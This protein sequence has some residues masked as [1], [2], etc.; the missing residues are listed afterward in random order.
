MTEIGEKGINLSGGQKTRISLARAVYQNCDMCFHSVHLTCSYLL[1]DPLSAVD[2]HVGRHIF[3]HCIKGLLANKCVVLVT[4]ALEFL[5]ACD[6]VI[7]LEKGAIADQGTFQ[8]V[9]QATSGVLAGLLQ[10]QKEAQAQQA[11]EESPISPVEVSPLDVSPLEASPVESEKKDESDG[12]KKDESDGE[13]KELARENSEEATVAVELSPESDAKKGELTVEETV[14]LSPESDAKKG[15]LTVEETRVKGKVKRSVYW[16]Y[17]LAA[18]GTCIIVVILLLFIL[19]Q[20]VRAINNWWL[21]YWSNDSAGKDAKWYLV[22]YIILGV[23]TVVVAIIAHLVL[24]F[25]GLKASSRLHDGLI[26]GILF[27]PMSFFD[28][29]PIGRI[30]N[31][32]SKDLYTVDKT[33][34]LVFDQ[35]LG[36]LFSVLST[37]VII[38][39]AFPLF[40]VILVIISIYYVYEG[41]YY[42]KSSREIKRLDSIS[43]SPIYANFGET[44]DGTSVIRA[45]QAEQQFIQKN[46]DLLDL[47]QRAYF[48]I[49][50]SNCWLGIRLEFAGTI[51]IGATALLSVLQKSS[52]SELFISMAALAISYSLDTT[53]DLNWVV[54]MVTDMETQIVSVERIE[55]Y[56][57]LPS[58]APAHIPDTQPSE[59]WPFK[60]DIAINQIVMRYRPELE[61]VIKELSV[62]ILPGEKVG[63]VGRTGAGKSSLVLCLMRIIELERGSIEIDGVDISKIGIS[64]IGLE[65]LR[66]KIAII[67]QEPLL[68]SGT[69]RDNLDPF[70]QYTDE[71]IWSALQR[72]SLRDLIAQDPAGLEKVVEEHGTNYSV[73]QQRQLLCVARALLRKSKVILM[74]EATASID[75]ETDMKIQKTIREEFS[76]STVITIA[77]RI[78][79]I[80]DSDKVMVMEMGRLKEFD[81]PSVLLSDKNSM[82]SQLV[83]KSK[84]IE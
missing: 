64:K 68:F 39:M 54:R 8:K 83:E 82:F 41:C 22:I 11:Q 49:S 55:E 63:V 21:T 35:F 80:I 76:E 34:P 72:A 50:S 6:Q 44:L 77:H 1:D 43:R 32:I 56:T 60:G 31:R 67:P 29:T 79:T 42:I 13:K 3:R 36:C 15:E 45:Y 19:A 71:E 61:P 7:V 25:T 4:H 53:Q 66:S 59:S 57:E 9:S 48:I 51:I 24:F 84:E 20:V 26:K 73:G 70:A 16:M 81:K 14:E 10:A 17:F 33:I 38:S 78:H 75:L 30:T 58:E 65:D 2:A 23:L 28:Q 40:L 74:D 27:S 47:N 12:E 69:I 5:P 18:G 46:Y 37:L 62:H 52:A